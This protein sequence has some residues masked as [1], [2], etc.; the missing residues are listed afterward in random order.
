M[1]DGAK[2]V[3]RTRRAPFEVRDLV[4]KAASE[5][6][7]ERGYHGTKTREIAERA[8]VAEPVIFRN[9]GSKAEI[10]EASILAPFTAFAHAWAASWRAEPLA[11]ADEYELTHTFVKGFYDLAL[12]HREVLR[13]LVAART[14]G[15]DPAL[16]EVADRV[17]D[18]LAELLTL[19]RELLVEHRDARSWG[20]IDPPVTVAVAFGAILAVVVL[21]EWVFPAGERRPGRARQVEELTQMLLNGVAHREA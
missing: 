15:G 2:R 18:Q 20:I 19:V 14:K 3:R 12:E 21:D 17:V 5:L 8:Q 6:F 16:A 4:L 11:A 13:T 9:V 1:V 10:F 7:A